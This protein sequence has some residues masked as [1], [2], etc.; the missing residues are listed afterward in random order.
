MPDPFLIAAFALLILGIVGSF[1]PV[2][3][4]AFLSVTGVLVYWWSTGYTD[5]S[6]VFVVIVA[7]VGVLTVLVDWFAG[8]VSAKIG[9]ASNVSTAAAA[10]VGFVLF[11]FAGPIGIILGVAATVFCIESYRTGDTEESLRAAFYSTLGVLASV[12][13]QFLVTLSILV[14]FVLAVAF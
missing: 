13:V 8:A 7:V 12:A 6:T 10:V 11:F 5:P 9:G 2:V 4:G 3:P 1:V 14:G